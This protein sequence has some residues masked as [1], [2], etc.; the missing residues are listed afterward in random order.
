M[1]L[2]AYIF[3][4]LGKAQLTNYDDNTFHLRRVLS[5]HFF[6]GENYKK[7]LSVNFLLLISVQIIRH[8]IFFSS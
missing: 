7:Y 8:V 1:L 6:S 4:A 5:V 2:A 3:L